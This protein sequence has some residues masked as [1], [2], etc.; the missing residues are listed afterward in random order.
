[1]KYFKDCAFCKFDELVCM[2]EYFID[3]CELYGEQSDEKKHLLA[4]CR[5][6]QK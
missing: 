4:E 1:M 3:I 6:L 5:E 2:L